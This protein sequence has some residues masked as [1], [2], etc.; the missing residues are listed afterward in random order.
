MK[1]RTSFFLWEISNKAYSAVRS[2]VLSALD[3]DSCIFIKS[4]GPVCRPLFSKMETGIL[5]A[6]YSIQITLWESYMTA[7]QIIV[8]NDTIFIWLQCEAALWWEPVHKIH[9]ITSRATVSNNPGFKHMQVWQ[10]SMMS[11]ETSIR[12][13]FNNFFIIFFYLQ[14]MMI[15]AHRRHTKLAARL[16]INSFRNK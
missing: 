12:D 15:L 9:A 11:D 10:S 16:H 3:K 8:W 4:L 6:R 13:K 1:L 2:Q 7:Q 5:T 14:W